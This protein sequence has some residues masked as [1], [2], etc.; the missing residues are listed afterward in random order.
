[1]IA[2]EGI[3]G[4][5]KTTLANTLGDRL[6]AIGIAVNTSKEPTRGQWGTVL[7]ESAASGRLT[8]DEELR[9][10]LLDR[11]QHV[12][13]LINPALSRGEV[14]ILDRYY[15]SNAA[16]QGA[17]GLDVTELL[18]QNDFAPQ[19]DV[20]LVLD[21]DPAEGLRRIRARG[22]E[23][24]LFETEAALTACRRIFLE[25][26]LP[27]RAVLDASKP[28]TQVEQQA[29]QHILVAVARKAGETMG[30]TAQAGEAVR[31]IGSAIPSCA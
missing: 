19:P 2:V 9:L 31:T 15:P 14:V 18:A 25:M 13:E 23:P 8:P 16:Y 17:A 10:L 12:D 3:D 24:N 29:W 4:A 6:R 21:L 28:A 26:P 20:V 27:T 5:G 1:M 7:R 11:R 30:L 22:D